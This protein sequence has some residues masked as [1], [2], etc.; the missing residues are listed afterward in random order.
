MWA[1]KSP[2]LGILSLGNSQ[3]PTQTPLAQGA[4]EISSL[5]LYPSEK[6][7]SSRALA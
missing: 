1:A 2:H 6:G 7:W 5:S 3:S 4:G